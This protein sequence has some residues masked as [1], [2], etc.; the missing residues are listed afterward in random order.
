ML[1]TGSYAS[2]EMTFF[3]VGPRLWSKVDQ[4]L[5]QC[6][7]ARRFL[8]K[9]P[10]FVLLLNLVPWCCYGPKLKESREY[11]PNRFLR[12]RFFACALLFPDFSGFEPGISL[13]AMQPNYSGV[14]PV[15]PDEA[16]YEPLP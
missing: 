7:V 6:E 8:Y 1:K 16:K 10:P 15:E 5:C 12:I 3:G 4:V 14:I 9:S 13:L 11:C 2:S